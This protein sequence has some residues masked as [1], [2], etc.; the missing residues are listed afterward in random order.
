MADQMNDKNWLSILARCAAYFCLMQSDQKD[1]TLAK[2]AKF[3]EGLGL[4]REDVAKM[5]GS[6]AP[7]ITELLR[8]DSTKKGGKRAKN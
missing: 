5:L 8:Q 6:T 3:L 4:A 7:S 1:K 2:K